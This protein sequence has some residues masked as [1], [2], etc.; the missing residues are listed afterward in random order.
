M[1]GGTISQCLK[2]LSVP[3]PNSLIFNFSSIPILASI[4]RLTLGPSFVLAAAALVRSAVPGGC[5]SALVRTAQCA[6]C[7]SACRGAALPPPANG[8]GPGLLASSPPAPSV[9]LLL[10]IHSSSATRLPG[11]FSAAVLVLLASC[12]SVGPGP[13]CSA[14]HLLVGPCCSGSISRYPGEQRLLLVDP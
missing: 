7:L 2:C 10:V 1:T 14:A 3:I 11:S 5:S 6:P 9:G 12:S 4:W 13:C 8:D